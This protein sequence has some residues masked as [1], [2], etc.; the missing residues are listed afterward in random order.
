MKEAE[1]KII[2]LTGAIQSGKSE[3]LRKWIIDKSVC[4]FITPTLGNTKKIFDLSSLKTYPY[5]VSRE[6]VD[7][8]KIGKYFLSKKAFKIADTLVSDA[9]IK[10]KE[11][12]V[13]DEIGKLE[14]NKQGHHNSVLTLQKYWKANLLF[15]VREGLV[16][17][18][19][20]T[21]KLKMPIV[22]EKENIENYGK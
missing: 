2:I 3:A 9:L 20:K 1:S 4:G 10:Q 6:N 21:Y 18:V 11:W 12:F 14:L 22:I 19:I 16:E 7:S 8:F 13:L 15:V 17:R 5:E